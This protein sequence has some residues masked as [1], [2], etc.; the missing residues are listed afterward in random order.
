MMQRQ[1]TW[2]IFLLSRA[3]VFVKLNLLR[4]FDKAEVTS[5][6]VV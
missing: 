4:R 2:E 3:E 6:V 5:P 1:T